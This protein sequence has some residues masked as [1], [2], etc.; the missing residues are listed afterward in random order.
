MIQVLYWTNTCLCADILVG[1]FVFDS[2]HLQ[3]YLHINWYNYKGILEMWISNKTANLK[4]IL[5][6]Y[7]TANFKYIYCC[8][9]NRNF[10]AIYIPF[11]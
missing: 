1:G 5:L 8:K 7:Q 3:E 2:P 6:L 11:C 9:I 10:I 4:Y